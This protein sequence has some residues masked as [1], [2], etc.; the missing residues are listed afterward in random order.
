MGQINEVLDKMLCHNICVLIRATH[1][2]GGSR[3]LVEERALN[4]IVRLAAFFSATPA[5]TLDDTV[6]ICKMHIEYGSERHE[7]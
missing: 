4:Q 7:Q 3:S 5:N 1:E 6:S 2:L